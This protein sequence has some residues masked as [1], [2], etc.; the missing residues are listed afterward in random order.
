MR[1]IN[2]L[3]PRNTNVRMIKMG[4]I[5]FKRLKRLCDVSQR[6]MTTTLLITS[7]MDIHIHFLPPPPHFKF[8]SVEIDL[9]SPSGAYFLR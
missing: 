5:V 6:F 1:I 8:R 2:A 9:L 7:Y 3:R 4:R